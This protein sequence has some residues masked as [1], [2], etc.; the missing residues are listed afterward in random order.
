MYFLCWRAGRRQ[1]S[2]WGYCG[3]PAVVYPAGHGEREAGQ[4]GQQGGSGF[5]ARIRS[6]I[7]GAALQSCASIS[8]SI[9]VAGLVGCG[10]WGARRLRCRPSTED[11]SRWEINHLP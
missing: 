2:G 6:H 7:D 8:P 9:L 1:G 10:L 3:L 4:R 11:L 5:T